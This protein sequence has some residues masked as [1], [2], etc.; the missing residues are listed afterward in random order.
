MTELSVIT[1]GGQYEHAM[2]P[3]VN[4]HDHAAAFV[5]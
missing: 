3:F 5:V 2:R 4:I 1:E